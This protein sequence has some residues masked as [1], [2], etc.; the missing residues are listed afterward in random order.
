MHTYALSFI[1][2]FAVFVAYMSERCEAAHIDLY[3]YLHGNPYFVCSVL[4]VKCYIALILKLTLEFKF[5]TIIPQQVPFNRTDKDYVRT[6]APAPILMESQLKQDC[7]LMT[8]ESFSDDYS[9][10]SSPL[11][12]F[13][14]ISNASIVTDASSANDDKIPSI[15]ALAAK[16][17]KRKRVTWIGLDRDVPTRSAPRKKP[18]R[19]RR[20]LKTSRTRRAQRKAKQRAVVSYKCPYLERPKNI[21]VEKKVTNPKETKQRRNGQEVTAVQYLTGTLYI[22]RGANPRVEFARKD[23]L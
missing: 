5:K 8:V 23:R 4:M 7:A 20:S 12:R 6:A 17:G 16:K 10:V 11:T 19:R 21:T 14:Y 3:C 13:G 15:N 18:T 22:Y 9:S 2:C 1:P